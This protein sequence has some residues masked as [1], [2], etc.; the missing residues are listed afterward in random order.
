MYR[1]ILLRLIIC[2][3][4]KIIIITNLICIKIVIIDIIIYII[5]DIIINIIDVVIDI[6][7]IILA[8]WLTFLYYLLFLSKEIKI[9][10]NLVMFLLLN[11]VLV[12]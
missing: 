9:S 1:L 11:F 3:V 8:I 2:I 7:L 6:V 5:I 12:L 10:C 4:E